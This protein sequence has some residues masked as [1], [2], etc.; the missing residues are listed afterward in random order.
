MVVI[1]Q[2][3]DTQI[4]SL[5]SLTGRVLYDSSLNALR[6]NDSSSYNNILLFKDTNNNVSGLNNIS[7]SITLV[8]IIHS[9]FRKLF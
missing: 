9:D 7:L 6:F 5:N 3:S 4:A 2:Y 8:L 1:K